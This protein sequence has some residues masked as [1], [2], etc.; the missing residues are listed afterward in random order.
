MVV[1]HGKAKLAADPERGMLR[2]K[3]LLYP[4]LGFA[5]LMLFLAVVFAFLPRQ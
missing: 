4:T 5:V 3:R 1:F 2:M